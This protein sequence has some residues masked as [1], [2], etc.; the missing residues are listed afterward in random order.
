MIIVLLLAMNLIPF[1]IYSLLYNFIIRLVFKSKDASP[2]PVYIQVLIFWVA[3]ALFSFLM[4]FGLGYIKLPS[5][6]SQLSQFIFFPIEFFTSFLQKF[7]EIH[8]EFIFY[9][10]FTY[11]YFW[12][13][14]IVLTMQLVRRDFKS[15]AKK[16]L[17]NLT[18]QLIA[19]IS[20][21]FI[22]IGILQYIPIMK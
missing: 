17:Y 18:A 14:L 13:Q 19:F 7:I 10:S 12:I 8:K 4:Y 21:S 9:M 16:F 11:L 22:I 3:T 1:I 15:Y 2:I 5:Q 20:T 6:L